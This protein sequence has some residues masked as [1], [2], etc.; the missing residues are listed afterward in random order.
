MAKVKKLFITCGDVAGI[1]PEVIV[2]AIGAIRSSPNVNYT[3]IGPVSQFSSLMRKHL[4]PGKICFVNSA[5]DL[6]LQPGVINILDIPAEDVEIGT[7]SKQTGEIALHSIQIA[8]GLVC[9]DPVNS[10]LITAPISKNAIKAAGSDFPGHTE[11]LAY[12][13]GV[14]DFV[15]MFLSPAMKGA[16]LTIHEPLREAASKITA[17]LIDSKIMVVYKTLVDQLKVRNPKLALL[18]INPHAGENGNIGKEEVE[19]FSEIIKR[20]PFLHGPFPADGFFAKKMYENYDVVISAYHDQ[21]LI[22]F[23][24]ISFT[25]GVNFTAGLPYIRTSPDHGTAFN[26]AGKNIADAGSMTAAL[27]WAIKFLG[28]K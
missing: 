21:L 14:G 6:C 12:L 27:Q 28:G 19:V 18:G 10:A 1:G 9:S 26:I 24:M 23:K 3:I 25:D 17:P 13:S 8:H 2:K 16:L 20:Y 4:Q 7:P 22:P 15:M 11:L 5:V